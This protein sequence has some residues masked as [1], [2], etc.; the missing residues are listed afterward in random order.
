MTEVHA[1]AIYTEWLSARLISELLL[2]EIL[3]SCYAALFCRNSKT[4]DARSSTYYR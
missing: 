2:V 1:I 3:T 4:T